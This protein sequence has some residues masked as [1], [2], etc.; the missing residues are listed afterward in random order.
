MLREY[1]RA[2]VWNCWKQVYPT[3][4]FRDCSQVLRWS[5]QRP[6]RKKGCDEC[7]WL[8]EKPCNQQ[9]GLEEHQTSTIWRIVELNPRSPNTKSPPVP[10]RRIASNKLRMWKRNENQARTKTGRIPLDENN[11]QTSSAPQKI[12]PKTSHHQKGRLEIQPTCLSV[13]LW[14]KSGA[15]ITKGLRAS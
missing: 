13:Q 10:T 15:A 3:K 9:N 5:T 14:E 1:N 7:N 2:H 11:G 6:E 4:R 12:A 8:Q